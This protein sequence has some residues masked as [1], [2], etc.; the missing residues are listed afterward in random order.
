MFKGVS[1]FFPLTFLDLILFLLLQNTI[2]EIK[3]IISYKKRN[4]TNNLNL[5]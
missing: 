1:K 5:I 4:Y 3:I 2:Q